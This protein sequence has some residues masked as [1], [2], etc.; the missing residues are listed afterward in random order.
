MRCAL[1][2]VFDVAFPDKREE[3]CPVELNLEAMRVE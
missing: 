3:H 2:D 1:D